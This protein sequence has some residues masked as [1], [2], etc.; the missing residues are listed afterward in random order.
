MGVSFV[1]GLTGVKCL[2][3]TAGINH[4]RLHSVALRLHSTYVIRMCQ[5]CGQNVS[6]GARHQSSSDRYYIIACMKC[7]QE[8]HA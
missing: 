8:L 4:V 3:R 7:V 2:S 5:Q 6:L 1:L